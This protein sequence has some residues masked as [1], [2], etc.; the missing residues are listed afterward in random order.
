MKKINMGGYAIEIYDAID[1]LPVIRFHKYNKFLLVDSGIGSDL[2]DFDRHVEKAI[3]YIR[4][5]AP[6]LAE[7]ELDNLRQ[8]VYFIQ[9][10][11]SPKYL[12]FAVLIKSVNGKECTDLSEEGLSKIIH[13][14]DH[15]PVKE[16]TATMEAVK[17]KIDYLLQMYF[18]NTFD[19]ATV[20]EYYDQLKQ[21]TLLLLDSIIN[22]DTQ[23]K[24]DEIERIT[25]ELL[26]YSKPQIFSGTG[27]L[28]IAYDKQF[29]KMCLTISEHLHTDPKKFTVLEYYN[30]FEYIKEMIKE[31]KKALKGKTSR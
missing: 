3:R 15:V 9:E 14:F 21:R 1:E 19:D 30:A 28:E 13:L 11:I 24:R 6:D 2:S 8:N 26:L 18:P 27:N 10:N 20:K 25:T 4:G 5:K 17:K 31:R 12:A 23:K 16:I 29:D 7:I 22:G